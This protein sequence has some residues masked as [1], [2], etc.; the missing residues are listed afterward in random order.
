MC[1]RLTIGSELI[2]RLRIVI[3]S[4]NYYGQASELILIDAFQ[5]CISKE[6]SQCA[7]IRK[8]SK[9]ISDQDLPIFVEEVLNVDQRSDDNIARSVREAAILPFFTKVFDQLRSGK[10][11]L[12]GGRQ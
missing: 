3:Q 6:L 7:S 2:S 11:M 9:R 8:Y 12:N 1:F 4:N 5:S 10:T